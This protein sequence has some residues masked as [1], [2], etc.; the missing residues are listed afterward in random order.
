MTPDLSVPNIFKK[1][2]STFFMKL[3]IIIPAICILCIL[4]VISTLL[5]DIENSGVI[6][7]PGLYMATGLFSFIIN[8]ILFI[9][10]AHLLAKLNRNE[11]AG[12]M[13]LFSSFKHPF[14][15]WFI[16]IL[17]MLI[18]IA[19]TLFFIVPGILLGLGLY[20]VLYL[21]LDEGHGIFDSFSR[22]WTLTKG[23]KL[24]IFGNSILMITLLFGIMMVAML[25]MFAPIVAQPYNPSY[26]PNLTTTF[27]LLILTFLCNGVYF[28]FGASMYNELRK[29]DYTDSENTE[30][31][32]H[33]VDPYKAFEENN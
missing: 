3:H 17:Y 14:K 13:S 8:P 21:A 30:D 25:F 18:C 12:V 7:H 24:S 5:Q 23:Y 15:C 32:S 11:K 27:A 6:K 26:T 10:F 33:T 1:T 9:G 2:F 31:E 4:P 29:V 28:S 19:G 22:A 20:T 16:Y